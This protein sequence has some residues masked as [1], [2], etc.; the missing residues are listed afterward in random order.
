[1][2]QNN[3]DYK[4]LN[5]NKMQPFEEEKQADTSHNNLISNPPVN[6]PPP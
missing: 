2:L 6:R 4:K 5:I 3:M 1:M